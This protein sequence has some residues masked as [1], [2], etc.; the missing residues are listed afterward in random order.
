ARVERTPS[1]PAAWAPIEHS[2]RSAR[3]VRLLGSAQR[4]LRRRQG[5][6]KA[7]ARGDDLHVWPAWVCSRFELA[8]KVRHFDGR[9]RGFDAFVTG[10]GAGALDGLLDGVARQDAKAD[11]NTRR[12]GGGCDAFG[13]F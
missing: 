1:P 13:G 12:A 7:T 2:Q 10:F 4:R 5:E 3:S 11:R 6:S 9:H 8:V